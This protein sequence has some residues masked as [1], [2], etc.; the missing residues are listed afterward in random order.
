MIKLIA[1]AAF[2]AALFS[3][4]LGGCHRALPDADAADTPAAPKSDATA[5]AAATPQPSFAS[6]PVALYNPATDTMMSSRIKAAVLADPQMQG[7]DV[8][9]NSQQGV[10]SLTGTV[11]SQEQIAIASAHAQREDGVMRVDNHLSLMPE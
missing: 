8:S 10:V 5:K 4:A 6:P 2:A 3:L 7:A 9:V 11:K 1:R